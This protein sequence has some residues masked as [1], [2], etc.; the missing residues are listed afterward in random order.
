[1]DKQFRWDY[2]YVETGEDNESSQY[3]RSGL[4]EEFHPS[5]YES[6]DWTIGESSSVSSRTRSPSSGSATSPV[7]ESS[8][9]WEGDTLASASDHE[10]A[11]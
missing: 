4:Y 5:S 11:R 6:D 10:Q 2:D 7:D 1:P 8:S 9:S 3:A